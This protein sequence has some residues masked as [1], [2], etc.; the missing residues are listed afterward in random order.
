MIQ[1]WANPAPL[2]CRS[3]SLALAVPLSRRHLFQWMPQAWSLVAA[4]LVQLVPAQALSAW[5]APG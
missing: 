1:Q 4:A 2:L 3:S 5:A